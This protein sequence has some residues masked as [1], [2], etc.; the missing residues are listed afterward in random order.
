MFL[1]ERKLKETNYLTLGIYSLEKS[2][3]SAEAI[4]DLSNSVISAEN[5]YGIHRTIE[6]NSPYVSMLLG[7]L[8]LGLL[9]VVILTG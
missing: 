1:G 7:R 4:A 3:I 5:A 6:R 2:T 9:F 8:K